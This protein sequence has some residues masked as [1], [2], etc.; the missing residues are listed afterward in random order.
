MVH[1]PK[2][3]LMDEPLTGAN[4]YEISVMM[5]TFREMVNQDRTVVLSVHQPSAEV[6]KLFDTVLL[7]SSGR[8]VYFGPVS[9]AANFFV[10]SPFGYDLSNYTNP[11]DFLADIAG[12]YLS[13]SKGEFI[14][15]A[16]L[17][18][19]YLQSEN[20][21]RLNLSFIPNAKAADTNENPMLGSKYANTVSRGANSTRDSDLDASNMS[22]SNGPNNHNS[23]EI[24]KDGSILSKKPETFPLPI[25]FKALYLVF[26]EIFTFPYGF[27]PTMWNFFFKA[28]ILLVRSFFALFNRY[29][30]IASSLVSHI[31]LGLLFGWIMGDTTSTTGIYNTTSFF[32]IGSLFLILTN[33]IFIFYM[34]N[35]HQVRTS[36]Y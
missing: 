20:Y 12:G 3:L 26:L 36:K 7:L 17:E 27:I 2:L 32:A 33:V 5:L 18:N 31:L 6:F 14:E 21:D 25:I 15:P 9:N 11:S 10:V 1:G 24:G 34:Y 28:E 13:D 4:P 23:I 29:E 19:Y 30:L 22:L 8:V 35:N 16:I